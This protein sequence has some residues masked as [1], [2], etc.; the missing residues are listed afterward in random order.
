MAAIIFLLNM[1]YKNYSAGTITLTF[2]TPGEYTFDDLYLV[3]QPMDS[4]EKQTDRLGEESLHNIKTE[5]NKLTGDI[6]VS[7]DKFLVFSIPY[8]A[9]FTAYVDGKKSKTGSGEQ[10]VYGGLS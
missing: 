8:N 2:S 1:G 5:T 4:V 6:E 7:S 3:C 9:G 10:Y